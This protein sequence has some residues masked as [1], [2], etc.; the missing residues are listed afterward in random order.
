MMMGYIIKM[1]SLG[2][3]LFL[4]TDF[5]DGTISWNT[6]REAARQQMIAWVRNVCAAGL[7]TLVD[8]DPVVTDYSGAQ[9]VIPAA[10]LEN[11]GETVHIKNEAETAL[12]SPLMAAA[13]LAA[14]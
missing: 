11:D 13:W 7:A 12:L 4:T 10:I 14:A 8:T 3:R 9:P 6:E 1:R 2:I 5:V